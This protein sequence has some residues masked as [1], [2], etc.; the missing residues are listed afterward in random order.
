MLPSLA[1]E[2]PKEALP[3]LRFPTMP[4]RLNASHRKALE[5]KIQ[6]AMTLGNNEHCKCRI[7][8]KDAEGMKYVETTVWSFDR[9]H[10]ILKSGIT[11]PIARVIDVELA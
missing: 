11:V 2:V 4:V 3:S 6:Q 8:F 10:I 7:L 9:E 5:R 1:L